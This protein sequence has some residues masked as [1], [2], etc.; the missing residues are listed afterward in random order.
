MHNKICTYD[1]ANP[2][3][4]LI[5]HTL[6]FTDSLRLSHII[7]SLNYCSDNYVEDEYFLILNNKRN[8]FP[9]KGD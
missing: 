9:I 4:I 5:P 1:D 7:L 3:G 2:S 6:F 8:K